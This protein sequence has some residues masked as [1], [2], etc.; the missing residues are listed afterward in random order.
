[1]NKM[2]A[3][4]VVYTFASVVRLDEEHFMLCEKS[5]MAKRL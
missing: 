3:C 1:M 2:F 5:E 4:N